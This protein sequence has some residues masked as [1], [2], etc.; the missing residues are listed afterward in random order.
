[1]TYSHNI[2]IIIRICMGSQQCTWHFYVFPEVWEYICIW[3]SKYIIIRKNA[4]Q[5]SQSHPNSTKMMENPSGQPT[6]QKSS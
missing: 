5:N 3:D 6:G 1:M 4:K 2:G